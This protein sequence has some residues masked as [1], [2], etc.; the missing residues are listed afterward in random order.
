MRKGNAY[1]LRPD[2]F[3]AETV[4]A[5]TEQ[6][7]VDTASMTTEIFRMPIILATSFLEL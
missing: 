5:A 2:R 6:Y 1:V 4:S 7:R 3:L